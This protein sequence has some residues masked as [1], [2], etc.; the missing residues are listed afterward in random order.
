MALVAAAAGALEYM[1]VPALRWLALVVAIGMAVE[2]LIVRYKWRAKNTGKRHIAFLSVPGNWML[3][4]LALMVPS[5]YIVGRSPFD[6][7]LLLIVISAADI[8]AW[9]FGSRFGD[10]K[11]WSVVS[12]NK[13][14]VG[15]I[16]GIICGAAAAVAY[17]FIDTAIMGQPQFIAQLLWV[18]IAVALLSQYGDLAASALKRKM[19]IKD[20]SNVLPGHGG[21][22]DRFDGWIFVLP[23]IALMMI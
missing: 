9:F 14:W 19:G 20:F 12:P 10:D 17:G 1:G 4:A 5:A 21:L 18:G 23:L 22:I 6:M 2:F 8:G 11:M 7:L 3:I 13:T 15:Q 16:A